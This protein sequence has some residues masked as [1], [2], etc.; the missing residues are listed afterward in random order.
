MQLIFK[1]VVAIVS[2]LYPFIVYWGL[3]SNNLTIVASFMIALLLLRLGALLYQ[4]RTGLSDL[5][6][7]LL[8]LVVIAFAVSANDI[9][10]FLYYPVIVNFALL[11]TF[12][13][14]LF[15]GQPV[16]TRFAQ[17]TTSLDD[18]GM[19]YTKRLTQIWA[20]FFAINGAVALLTIHISIDVWTM[21]NGVIS[22]CLIALLAGGEWVYRKT[23]L[24]Q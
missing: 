3:D 22:Y 6:P 20:I 5:L 9:I 17:M 1:L 16:I 19:R 11:A 13:L 15:H 14:S 23:V 2:V 21:Y 12:S 7:I 10:G 18:A 8:G 24:G 4:K